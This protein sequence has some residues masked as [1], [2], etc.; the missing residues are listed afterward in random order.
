MKKIR[1]M[2]I[3]LLLLVS[4]GCFPIFVPVDDGRGGRGGGH[5]D[6]GHG[7]GGGDRGH[8]EHGDHH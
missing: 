6:H 4:S 7:G 5:E 1:L 3:S 2:I 8:E